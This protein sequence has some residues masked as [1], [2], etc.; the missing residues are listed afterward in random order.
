M[1]GSFISTKQDRFV[2]HSVTLK[3]KRS[4]RECLLYLPKSKAQFLGIS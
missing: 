2:D 4:F 1:V 3:I